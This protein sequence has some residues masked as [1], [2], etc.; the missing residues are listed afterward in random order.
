MN[1]IPKDV[2]LTEIFPRLQFSELVQL[3]FIFPS[4]SST[5]KMY[6]VQFGQR[7]GIKNITE[8]KD[9]FCRLQF[10]KKCIYAHWCHIK[11]VLPVILHLLTIGHSS[12]SLFQIEDELYPQIQKLQND[13]ENDW[14]LN[15]DCIFGKYIIRPSSVEYIRN[16]HTF[17]VLTNE[18]TNFNVLQY[19]FPRFEKGLDEIFN[20]YIQRNNIQ[21]HNIL[22]REWKTEIS[23]R[24]VV[25]FPPNVFPCFEKNNF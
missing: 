7:L 2:L 3:L 13:F 18:I 21:N 17:A 10:D 1:T 9:V 11:N 16:H 19:L 12:N 4:L 14:N 6:I 22:L 15:L 25:M 24:L 23:Q 5:I 20:K 8:P